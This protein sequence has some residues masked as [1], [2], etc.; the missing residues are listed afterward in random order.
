MFRKHKRLPEAWRIIDCPLCDGLID[1][2]D[3]RVRDLQA[4]YYWHQLELM[5]RDPR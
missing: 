2:D 1:G 5:K 3:K 4:H